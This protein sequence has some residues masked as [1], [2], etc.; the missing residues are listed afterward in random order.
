M[1]AVAAFGMGVSAIV[2]A[3]STL[4]FV[5]DLC[6][7]VSARI[8]TGRKGRAA[9]GTFKEVRRS[10]IKH[11]W[12]AYFG[13]AEGK[14]LFPDLEAV[15][16]CLGPT[17]VGKT[18]KFILPGILALT[19]RPQVFYDYKSDITPQVAPALRG[20][21]RRLRVINLGGLYEREVGQESDR[22]NVLALI[23]ETFFQPGGLEDV[24]DQIR[25][26]CFVLDP[27]D[28]G[29]SGVSDGNFWKSGSR[30]YLG[31]I[32]LIVCLVEGGNASLGLCLQL[33]N[34]KPSLLR[35][36]LWAAGRL[37]AEILDENGEPSA[38]TARFPMHESPWAA[39]HDP[40]EV[41]NFAE[42]LRA[43]ASGI[44]DILGQPD[45]KLADSILSTARESALSSFGITS[46]A[47]K[48]TSGT[49][50]LRFSELKDE[51][52]C[53]A[54]AVM[55]DPG[56]LAA[57]SDVLGV[58]HWAMLTELRRH[59]RKTQ[60]VYIWADEAGNLPWPRI[61]DDLT[62]LRGY[63]VVPILA[64][65]NFAHFEKRHGK[66]GL[67]TLLSEAQ[68]VLAMPG[69]RSPETLALLERRLSTQSVIAKSHNAN[70]ATGMFSMDGYSLQEDGRPLLNAEEI[71]RLEKGI[72]WI[73]NHRPLL[74]DM[75]SVAEIAPFRDQL[76]P[77]PFYGVP[78]RKRIRLR[79]RP[80]S[81]SLLSWLGAL[82]R[83]T[84]LGG[85]AS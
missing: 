62:T 16:F 33:A 79:I 13:V 22:Y 45:G 81:R 59:E 49:S 47:A 40:A 41:E 70:N 20:H 60:K 77:S 44:A 78:Y 37:E 24:P 27:D 1:P 15:A 3:T 63:G 82:L 66:A 19:G 32:I 14:P 9:F 56:K 34:D 84:L 23:C 51:G 29:K 48:L 71:R 54:I 6:G 52:S 61:A 76:A 35:H 83:R 72:L 74:V 2:L 57:H 42:F 26:L 73:G 64:F 5:A 68:V 11:G 65:Q 21:G 4:T 50:T 12:G 31:F 38:E 28:T 67:A 39:L 58:L 17:G 75:P 85:A 80:Y 10:L 18:T 8:P 36:A 53:T 30:R 46:R 55:I 25:E 43:L 7:Y 69:Q